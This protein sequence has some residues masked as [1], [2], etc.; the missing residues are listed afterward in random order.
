MTDGGDQRAG[1]SLV[2]LTEVPVDRVK[3]IGTVR[4]RKLNEDGIAS[5]AHL[6]L[7]V[8]RRYLDRSQLFDLSSVPLGE[9]VTVGGVVR[10]VSRRRISRNRTMIEAVIGDGTSTLTAVWFNPYLKIGEGE[11]VV[12]S[13]KAELFRGRLQMKAPDVGRFGGRG[14]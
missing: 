2:Y 6:L 1:R 4:A 5:V 3:G 12:L 13:G 14:G 9:E 7:H 8:P 10:H 11:E